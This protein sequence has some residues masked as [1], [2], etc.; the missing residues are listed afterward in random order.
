[1]AGRQQK[2]LVL[3][4]GPSINQIDFDRLDPRIK[5]IGVNRIWLKHIPDY[6]YFTDY[7]ILRELNKKEHEIS[8]IKLSQTS[9][10]YASEWLRH[11]SKAPIPNWIRVVPMSDRS[12]FPD[13]V[14]WSIRLFRELYLKNEDRNRYT[15]Y[16]AGV[17]L[18]WSNPSHFWKEDGYKYG[19]NHDQSWYDVRF[20]KMYENFVKLKD[21]GIKM[22]SSTPES[23]LNGIL[24]YE[25]ISNLYSK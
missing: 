6:F 24:R 13:S 22:I 1:M 14:S 4:N 21:S 12:L 3:G 10:C 19:N 15:F 8:K 18:K 5:T 17:E 25:N 20:R 2:I 11:N 9:K 7:P 23:R 16:L